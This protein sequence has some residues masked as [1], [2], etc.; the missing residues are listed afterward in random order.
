MSDRPWADAL[1]INNIAL[2]I[3]GAA[4][5]ASPFCVNYG[6][7]AT[8]AAVFGLGIGEFDSSSNR[9]I[10]PGYE[11]GDG[12]GEGGFVWVKNLNTTLC[13]VVTDSPPKNHKNVQSQLK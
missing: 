2:M 3:G 6:M 4:T 9:R 7:F 10:T 5:I 13:E 11:V 8:Y 12:D 1:L